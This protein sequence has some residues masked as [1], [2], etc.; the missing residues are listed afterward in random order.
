MKWSYVGV[1][2]LIFE[3]VFDDKSV[4]VLRFLPA[5]FD[6]FVRV[7]VLADGY[8]AADVVVFI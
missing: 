3:V 5:D 4:G 7:V 1:R 6:G 2:S 8:V